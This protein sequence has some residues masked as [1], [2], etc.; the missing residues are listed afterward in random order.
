MSCWPFLVSVW[1]VSEG[2]LE[3]V[4]KVGETCPECVWKVFGRPRL[5]YLA[6]FGPGIYLLVS[7][8][9][10]DCVWR[11]SGKCKQGVWKVEGRCFVGLY[12]RV[13]GG[14]LKGV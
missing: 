11:V 7:E 1:R 12:L 13:S 14:F 9:C 4:W 6:P 3:G 10:V 8:C 5:T 2:C